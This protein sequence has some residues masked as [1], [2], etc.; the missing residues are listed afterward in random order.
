[1]EI[2]VKIGGRDVTFKKNGATMLLYKQIFG[3]EYFAD[4]AKVIKSKKAMKAAE[5]ASDA[6]KPKK[7]KPK[8]RKGKPVDDMSDD[9]SDEELIEIA[10]QLESIDLEVY[11]N[12]LYVLAKAADPAIPDQITWLSSFDDFDVMTIF[13]TVSPMLARELGV[14]AKNGYPAATG[15]AQEG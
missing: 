2:T 4:L 3:R 10:K 12:I 9:M 7:D 8:N 15:T 14:D 13:N 11:Y 6:N 5:I 1:M